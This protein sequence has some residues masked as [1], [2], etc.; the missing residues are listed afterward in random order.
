MRIYKDESG[1]KL[2]IEK[3]LLIA[4]K[5]TWQKTADAVW[6]SLLETARPPNPQEESR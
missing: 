5:Y 6:A 3:G 2:L 1:R 4:E